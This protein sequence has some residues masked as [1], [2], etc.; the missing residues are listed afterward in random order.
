MFLE[1]ISVFLFFFFF[2]NKIFLLYME[3][4]SEAEHL[5]LPLKHLQPK[6]L[7]MHTTHLNYFHM[8]IKIF[9]ELNVCWTHTGK[10]QYLFTGFH[11]AWDSLCFSV[12]RFYLIC[13]L[14]L[15]HFKFLKTIKLFPCCF[16]SPIVAFT[17]STLYQ[18]WSFLK[19]KG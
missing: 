19:D 11:T 16:S 6:Y 7:Q 5:N 3:C 14:K 10:L 15:F 4:F 18:L 2:L 1:K 17:Y 9:S 8:V 13:F 12:F